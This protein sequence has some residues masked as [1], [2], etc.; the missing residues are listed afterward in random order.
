MFT[1]FS[2]S[3]GLGP[4]ISPSPSSVSEKMVSAAIAV[5]HKYGLR[6]PEC[7]AHRMTVREALEAAFAIAISKR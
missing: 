1:S 4:I 7:L 3:K 5:L 6:D 2:D